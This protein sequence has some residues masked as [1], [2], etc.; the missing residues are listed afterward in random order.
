[1]FFSCMVSLVLF[2]ATKFTDNAMYPSIKHCVYVAVCAL[3]III[4]FFLLRSE[5]FLK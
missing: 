5:L 1:M 3:A 2:L 4:I